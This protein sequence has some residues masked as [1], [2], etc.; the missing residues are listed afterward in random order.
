MNYWNDALR[1]IKEASIL[2]KEKNFKGALNKYICALQTFESEDTKDAWRK[3][4]EENIKYCTRKIKKL[5]MIVPSVSENVNIN[6]EEGEQSFDFL[7]RS[8]SE[9]NVVKTDLKFRTRIKT[10]L[11]VEK[12]NVKFDDVCGLES[13]KE[14]LIQSAILPLKQ[15]QLFS[16]T[17][18]PYKGFL[19]FGVSIV[20]SSDDF[21]YIYS[22]TFSPQEPEKHLLQEHWQ[23]KFLEQTFFQHR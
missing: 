3:E 18:K 6:L 8:P 9:K 15:P 16:E 17:T 4:T 19:L 5:E 11:L 2:E 14:N 12:P 22:S 20:Y 1:A 10:T 13:L 21:L 23:E 7:S